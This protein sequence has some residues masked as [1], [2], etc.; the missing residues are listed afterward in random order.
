METFGSGVRI[1]MEIILEIQRNRPDHPWG[2]RAFFEAAA[3]SSAHRTAAPRIATGAGRAAATTTSASASF[4]PQDRA[5]EDRD[6]NQKRNI[7][8]LL[9]NDYKTL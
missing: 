4:A 3:G 2:H 5:D 6:S 8:E 9:S 7:D 1:I